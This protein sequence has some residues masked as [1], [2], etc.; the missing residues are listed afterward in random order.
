MV[1]K[2]EGCG[3]WFEDV[4][5]STICP[6]DAFPANMGDNTFEIHDEAYLS[7]VEPDPALIFA[8]HQ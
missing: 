8:A 2:C 7:D 3:K 6:H 1:V 5:R 4:F